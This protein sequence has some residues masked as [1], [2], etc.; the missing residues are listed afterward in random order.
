MLQELIKSFDLVEPPKT[1]EYEYR[2]YYNH[3]GTVY[4]AT[5]LK[6]DP[7]ESSNYIIVDEQIYKNFVR[8]KIENGV[9]VLIP[10]S[11]GYVA[12]QLVRSSSGVAVVQNHMSLP[13]IEENEY[14]Q[15]EYYDYHTNRHS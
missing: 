12:N 9:P 10:G 5:S 4:R 2:L 13:L 15:I 6:S 3:E 8:Y 1:I 14:T 7:M 11:V